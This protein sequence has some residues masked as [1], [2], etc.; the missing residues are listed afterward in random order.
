MLHSFRAPEKRKAM[1]SSSSLGLLFLFHR[2]HLPG[3]TFLTPVKTTVASKKSFRRFGEKIPPPVSLTPPCGRASGACPPLCG[4]RVCP[5]HL[6]TWM[7]KKRGAG[8]KL[9]ALSFVRCFRAWVARRRQ[10]RAAFW[11]LCLRAAAV[12]G[13]PC[14]QNL[15]ALCFLLALPH[16]NTPSNCSRKFTQTLAI[17][18]PDINFDINVESLSNISLYIQSDSQSRFDILPISHSDI[19]SHTDSDT[20]SDIKSVEKPLAL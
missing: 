12:F 20:P 4:R 19:P 11:S 6:G 14:R 17:S 5:L 9:P 7:T 1:P 3:G 13:G 18:G 10:L 2:W 15:P 16:Q 8:S